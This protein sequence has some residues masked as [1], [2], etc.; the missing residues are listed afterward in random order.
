VRLSFF[1]SSFSLS[2][3]AP[4]KRAFPQEKQR[5]EK[6]KE[7][8]RK[9]EE[10]GKK[11][12]C[13]CLPAQN[14]QKQGPLSLKG[15]GGRMSRAPRARVALGG[16]KPGAAKVA[17]AETSRTDGDDVVFATAS[18]D[19]L[20]LWRAKDR[21]EQ[22][23]SSHN[24]RGFA[25]DGG[26]QCCVLSPT[27]NSLACGRSDGLT[28]IIDPATGAELSTLKPPV[29]KSGA[30]SAPITCVAFSRTGQRLLTGS[31]VGVVRVW[32]MRT[33]AC[34]R[35]LRPA[36]PALG[37]AFPVLAVA[38]DAN[39]SHVVVSYQNDTADCVIFNLSTGQVTTMLPTNNEAVTALTFSPHRR[40]WVAACTEGGSV[41]VWDTNARAPAAKVQPVGVR[42]KLNRVPTLEAQS[43]FLGVHAAPCTGVEF[44]PVNEMLLTSSGLDKVTP[45][46][47]ARN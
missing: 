17:S 44:S 34:V 47:A 12:G 42:G 1:A 27:G 13:S 3:E 19:G 46:A 41:Y 38:F 4:K 9:E 6:E 45:R 16:A 25:W 21:E 32:E 31:A 36:S 15:A 43:E 2:F 22:Q 33:S 29:A 24:P 35:T 40:S 11:E 23:L 5:G 26:A 10:G 8:G 39:A 30:V 18:E 37:A 20:A 14:I 28:V 7:R